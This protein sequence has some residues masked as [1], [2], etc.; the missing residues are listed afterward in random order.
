[1]SLREHKCQRLI[2]VLHVCEDRDWGL[3][4]LSLFR[5]LAKFPCSHRLCAMVFGYLIAELGCRL[6]GSHNEHD[7]SRV[8]SRFLCIAYCLAAEK[9][10]SDCQMAAGVTSDTVF[11]GHHQWTILALLVARGDQTS[12]PTTLGPTRTD[13]VSCYKSAAHSWG[14]V[15]ASSTLQNSCWTRKLPHHMQTRL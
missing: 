7:L 3:S 8:L 12:M 10:Y 1:M 14:H 13:R 6:V 4:Q 9:G 2:K 15:L 11:W 5:V